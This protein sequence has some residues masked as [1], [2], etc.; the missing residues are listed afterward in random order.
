MARPWK[1]LVVD[2]QQ[3]KEIKEMIEGT[4]TLGEQDPIEVETCERFVDALHKLEH[5]RIDL[6]V[7]DLK[8]DEQDTSGT[9]QLAGEQVFEKIRQSLFVPVIFYTGLAH[10]VEH[11]SN[12]FVRVLRREGADQIRTAIKELFSTRI[13]NLLRHLEEEKRSYMWD[14]LLNQGH[15]LQGVDKEE[16]AFL[17]ARRLAN[18]LESSAIRRF[19]TDSEPTGGIETAVIHPVE[20]YIYPPV[21]HSLLT[22]D[23]VK[24]D[25]TDGNAEYW[26]ILTPS[27]DL[28]RGRA[29]AEMVLLARC[30]ELGNT[31]EVKNYTENQTN[32]NRKI[33]ECLIRNR[34]QGRQ[35]FRY[36]FLPRT[37]FLPGF[38]VD[39]QSLKHL[40]FENEGEE[41]INARVCSLDNPFAEALSAQF[42]RYYARLGTP[43]LNIEKV[44]K[45]ISNSNSIDG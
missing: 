28:V 9:E 29:K 5:N 17:L 45:T 19:L 25:T 22:G 40:T 12:P 1:V 11:M 4:K 6:I 30:I 24:F 35:E 42:I 44:V 20:M 34:G 18:L 16:V 10:K 41:L 38:L 7:L 27:C 36:H 3:A 2:D 13:P 26:V 14:T 37:S 31:T 39:F 33:I 23:I 43:D 15:V 21:E 8:D 32:K